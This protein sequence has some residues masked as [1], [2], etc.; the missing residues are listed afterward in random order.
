MHALKF[1]DSITKYK[2]LFAICVG[3]FSFGSNNVCVN[4]RS[5]SRIDMQRHLSRTGEDGLLSN[6]LLLIGREEKLK[7]ASE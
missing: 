1:T 6:C 3:I 7:L 2:P 5:D 4:N